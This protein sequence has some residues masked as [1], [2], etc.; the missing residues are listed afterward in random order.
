[1]IHYQNQL[2]RDTGRGGEITLKRSGPSVGGARISFGIRRR[3]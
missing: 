2:D 3:F 1:V